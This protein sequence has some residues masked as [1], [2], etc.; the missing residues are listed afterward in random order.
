MTNLILIMREEWIC[1]VILVFLMINS[2][3]YRIGKD[4]R[5][6]FRLSMFAI[7]H[8][9]FDIITVYT[10]N[11]VD[12]LPEWLNWICH[13]I[14]Y[15]CAIMFTYE[16]FCYTVAL[17]ST[18]ENYYRARRWAILIPMGY[19][20][21]L[22][23]L[24][25]T[26]LQ[27]NGTKYSF[28]PAVYAGYSVAMLLI[29]ASGAV[30]IRN[31][32]K[33]E[34]HI[35]AALAPMLIVLAAAEVVQVLVPE[36]LFTGGGATIITIGVF[37]ALENPAFVF[38]RKAMTDALTGVKSRSGY[39][40]DMKV[41][42]QKYAESGRKMLVSFVFCDIN[43]LKAVNDTY[44]HLMG[45]DYIGLIAQILHAQLVSAKDIYR[46]GGDEF[47]AVY[48][49][50][51]KS[52]I[53]KEIRQVHEECERKKHTYP[54]H[55]SVAIGW[56]CSGEAFD[57]LKDVLRA[58]DHD[59]YDKKWQMKH[60]D[61]PRADQAGTVLDKTGLDSRIFEAFAS[62]SKRSYI[63]LCNLQ[64][65]VSRWSRM[66]VDYFGLPG[67]YMY[68]AGTIWEE[69]IHP[70]DREAYRSD[71]EQVF[72]GKKLYHDMEYRARNLAGDYV[73]CTCRGT[74]LRGENGEP[75]LFAGTMVNHGIED[76]I[77]PV[78][79]L[80]TVMAFLRSVHRT[81]PVRENITVMNISVRTF[82]HVNM[83]YGYM[84]GN[85]ILKSLA[86]VIRKLLAER[87][88]VFRLDGPQFAICLKESER[89]A[90][91][92]FYEELQSAAET[93]IQFNGLTV[94]LHLAGSAMILNKQSEIT[95]YLIRSSLAYALLQSK[96]E[97]NGQL[98]FFG[99]RPRESDQ[100][101]LELFGKLQRSI[102]SGCQGYYLCYQ[103]IVDMKS[104][105]I[106]GMEALLRWQENGQTVSPGQFILWLEND[107]SFPKLSQW[108]L[109]QAV[110]D[111]KPLLA[112]HPDFRLH[113]N[114]TASQLA[115]SDFRRTTMS[116]LREE[117]YP[118]EA[119]TMELTERCRSL[120]TEFL[121]EQINFFR[122][123]GI[124]IEMDDLGTGSSS[125]SLLQ[126]LPVDSVK[127]DQSFIRGIE[128]QPDNQVFV[129]SLVELGLGL[130]LNVCLEGVET[131]ETYDYLQRYHAD[132]YQGYY[133]STPVRIEEFYRLLDEW[134]KV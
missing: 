65:N 27:G 82:A 121:K 117:D 41:L 18:E 11:H 105:Q 125:L 89:E 107:P 67:E 30:L 95:D 132:S 25:I 50:T 9:I 58:A 1:L 39:D 6:F 12:T 32:K 118:P 22:P 98:V 87:G 130:H 64:T 54:F 114:I 119:F 99:D 85:E 8:V 126:T 102:I 78:T 60:G 75:D 73:I 115:R 13:V 34:K 48:R 127:V 129:Q 70:M 16:L 92:K 40:M 103:P 101:Q 2:R 42:E 4:N 24:P 100:E 20:A 124:R 69:Y 131:K 83:V 38:R 23:F 122:S 74:I 79:N 80:H 76:E 66:A 31:W 53:E 56:A 36:L 128:N 86:E 104:N 46:M 21:A 52:V 44:G 17:C 106:I 14:F 90:V 5:G 81:L 51:D 55:P 72:S 62:T 61:K 111:A 57:S 93:Q 7:G 3:F 68:D 37:F 123:Y 77:D 49:F 45:D 134:G 97:K 110:Q 47:L 91:R 59:M 29:F 113:V 84:G 112:D 96:N 71:I 10:V 35:L 133:C 94:P 116:I 26:Y 109:R 19:V 43:G 88:N 63:Y 28:G 33:L 120:D 108:I 15:L